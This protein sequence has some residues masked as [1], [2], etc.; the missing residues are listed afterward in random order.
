MSSLNISSTLKEIIM[1][2][3]DNPTISCSLTAL[4]IVAAGMSPR[5]MSVR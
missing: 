5:G 4:V 1:V 3:K 2:D